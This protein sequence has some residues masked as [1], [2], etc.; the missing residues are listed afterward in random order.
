[1]R[2]VLLIGAACSLAGIALAP[3]RSL[4]QQQTPS[5]ASRMGRDEAS[6]FPLDRWQAKALPRLPSGMTLEMIRQ[7]DSVFQAAGAC[8]SCHG[9]NAMGLPDKGSGLSLGLHFVPVEWTA[10]DSL[11]TRGIPESVTRTSI[12]MPPRGAGSNLTP[13]QTRQVAAYVWAIAQTYGEPWPGG[14][15]THGKETA[16]ASSEP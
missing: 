16:R 10:I 14:H 9:P 12:A 8:I 5:G 6:S 2:Y 3:S 13:E 4:A 7:G 1:M 15:K 11:V